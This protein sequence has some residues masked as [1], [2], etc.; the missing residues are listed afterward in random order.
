MLEYWFKNGNIGL[1]SIIPLF[2]LYM[3]LKPV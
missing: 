2:L 3:A 1:N